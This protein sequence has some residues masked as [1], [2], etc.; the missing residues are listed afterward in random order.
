MA[1]KQ[2]LK[3]FILNEVKKAFK[4][5]QEKEEK[6]VSP[7]FDFNFF[8]TLGTFSA[9]LNYAKKFLPPR[10]CLFYVQINA[11]EKP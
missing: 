11:L 6:R 10:Q 1:T 2:I 3:K 7:S 4:E 8:K 5:A 9:R